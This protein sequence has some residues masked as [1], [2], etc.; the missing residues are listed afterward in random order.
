M[1]SA[2]DVFLT[3]CRPLSAP[4]VSL[5]KH[6]R[7]LREPAG[8]IQRMQ[9]RCPPNCRNA[10]EYISIRPSPKQESHCKQAQKPREASLYR[11][12]QHYQPFFLAK[13]LFRSA[14]TFGTLNWTYSRSSASWLS[15]C[16]SRRSSSFRSSSRRPRVLPNQC[17]Y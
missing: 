11:N 1:D 14:S 4:T 9:K 3:H 13:R 8:G 10:T 7:I 2:L 16:I 12:E 17:I 6:A 5:G 15:F